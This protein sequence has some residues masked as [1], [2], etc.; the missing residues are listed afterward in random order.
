MRLDRA[1]PG[2]EPGR[3]A[4]HSIAW[5][6]SALARRNQ[7]TG[8]PQALSDQRSGP[9]G[10]ESGEITHA[11]HLWL[12]GGDGR[13]AGRR[14]RAERHRGGRQLCGR[15]AGMIFAS[16]LT[17]AK[18][19]P[20]PG[21]LPPTCHRHLSHKDEATAASVMVGYNG[22]IV[23]AKS[24]LF[25]VRRGRIRGQAARCDPSCSHAPRSPPQC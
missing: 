2:V 17:T 19:R 21:A 16:Q 23:L 10:T 8:T 9:R 1:L 7:F 15:P 22:V 25:H 14:V 20:L 3:S 12:R 6:L 4:T 5:Y 11:L 13:P 18:G 24:G